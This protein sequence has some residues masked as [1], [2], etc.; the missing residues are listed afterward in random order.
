MTKGEAIRRIDSQMPLKEKEALGNYV[1]RNDAGQ[2][3]LKL[4]IT[5]GDTTLD[6]EPGEAG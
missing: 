6:R 5:D 2:A 3:I 1:I 4:G